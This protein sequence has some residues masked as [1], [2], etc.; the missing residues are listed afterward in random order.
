MADDDDSGF[1]NFGGTNDEVATVSNLRNTTWSR[2]DFGN[3]SGLDRVYNH[4]I[5]TAGFDGFCD[6]VGTGGASEF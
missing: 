5:E 3:G 2:G 6:V 4:E 1:G